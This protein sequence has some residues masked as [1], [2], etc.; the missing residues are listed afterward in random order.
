MRFG[1]TVDATADRMGWLASALVALLV[2][3]AVAFLAPTVFGPIVAGLAPLLVVI[4]VIGLG[5]MWWRSQRRIDAEPDVPA[6]AERGSESVDL[7]GEDDR[8]ET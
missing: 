7:R 3:S 8:V 1:G 6:P 5:A 2:L 4:A